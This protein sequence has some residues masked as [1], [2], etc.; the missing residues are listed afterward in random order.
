MAQLRR[1]DR[2]DAA[3]LEFLILTAARR[4]EARAAV[5]D[6]IK[7]AEKMWVIPAERMKMRKEHRVPLSD[8]ALV[9]LDRMKAHRT[10]DFIFPGKQAGK[11]I[12]ALAMFLVLRRLGRGDVTTHG[13]RSSFADWAKETTSYPYELREQALAHTKEEAYARGDLFEKRRRLMAD[14][15]AYCGRLADKRGTVVAL[16]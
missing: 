11:P 10:S 3:C 8:A 2:I 13:F 14:W 9:V 7:F 6:E 4:D 16:N 5:W 15:A 1:L 12:G